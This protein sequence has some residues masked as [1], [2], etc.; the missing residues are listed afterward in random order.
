MK[1]DC[2]IVEDLLPLYQEGLVS[3][4]SEEAIEEHLKECAACSQELEDLRKNPAPASSPALSLQ[5]I[6]KGLRK[7][8]WLMVL[9]V[10]MLLLALVSAIGAYSTDRQYL[11]YDKDE[12]KII[13]EDGKYY[14]DIRRSD[15]MWEM[16]GMPSPESP[17]AMQYELSAFRYRTLF[18]SI[19]QKE[20]PDWQRREFNWTD[21][22]GGMN[23]P[24]HLVPNRY[25]LGEVEHYGQGAIYY[26]KTDEPAVL[27]IGQDLYPDGGYMV[28]PRL[29]LV[30]YVW[31]AL[32]LVAGLG[33]LLFIFRKFTKTR[34]V[35]TAL[36]GLPLSYLLGHLMVKGVSTISMYD[37]RRDLRW[38]LL[39]AAFLFLA[40]LAFWR[41]H[42]LKQE[43]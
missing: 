41:L 25:L 3:Q 19:A 21:G 2:A 8:R 11:S 13:Q 16:T 1:L 24:T 43:G 27:L 36:L 34:R 15:V 39:C 28:L 30:F 37:M 32:G 42:R 18:G 22:K 4:Q 33:M 23:D 12:L 6:A 9:L 20:V 5:S 40:W 10:A 17:G 7:R 38:I 14:L 35:L 31:L 29:A 26:V